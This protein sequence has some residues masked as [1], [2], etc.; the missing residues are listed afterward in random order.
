[1]GK[2][3][4]HLN[5]NRLVALEINTTGNMPFFHDLVEISA[6]AMTE[7]LE[8]D[9]TIMPFSMRMQTKRKN[10]NHA[11]YAKE[12]DPEDAAHMFEKW[13]EKLGLRG[14]KRIIPVAVHWQ[15]KTPFL[16]DWLGNGMDGTAFYFDFF[17]EKQVRDLCTISAYWNDLASTN[18]E[19]YPFPKDYL[20]NYARRFGIDY[21]RPVTTLTKALTII[22]VF[23][24]LAD[25]R[26]NTGIQLR[27]DFP[28]SDYYDTEEEEECES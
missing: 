10:G 3:M 19:F 4:Q 12:V 26:L 23:E 6:V 1:M 20:S 7:G 5:G 18:S 8:P 16:F 24:K 21:R 9:K 28:R 25:T 11:E 14:S 17:H 27:L 2:I 13:Y 15:N 22:N